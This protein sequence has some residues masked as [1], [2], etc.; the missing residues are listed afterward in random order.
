MTP[1]RFMQLLTSIKIWRLGP[2]RAPHK[3]LLLLLALGNLC[4]R[5]PR[6]QSY[7]AIAQRLQ[8]LL[9]RFGPPSRTFHPEYPFLRLYRDGLWD[10]QGLQP[11]H[12]DRS[13]QL[14]PHMLKNS[15]VKG[16]L[17]E[18][19][20]HLLVVNPDLLRQAAE[21]LLES[22]FPES[23]HQDLLE[24]VNLHEIQHPLALHET[25]TS[26]IVRPRDPRFRVN[27]IQAYEYRCAICGYDIRID[28]QLMGLEAAHIRWHANGGP[29]EVTNGLAL[30]VIH[31]KA[32]DRGGI[33]L[34]NELELLVSTELHGQNEAWDFWFRKYEGQIIRLP[35][36]SR[37]EPESRHL[38]WH[39]QQVF[40][41]IR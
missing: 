35:R 14:R 34:S 26:K 16:G 20:F 38:A 29:D 39:R 28:D 19:V 22:H 37:N 10:I 11:D 12:L 9:K 25:V 1:D 18:E 6:M 4:Q 2:R 24:A 17:P 41:G 3:P 36:Q 31:H 32:F 33:G 40:R 15:A 8:G 23:F 30:C 27:V 21:Y 13:G 7:Q 5:Q